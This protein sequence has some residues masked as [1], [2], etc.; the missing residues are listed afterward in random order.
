M[1]VGG[2]STHEAGALDSGGTRAPC[3]E[4]DAGGLGG[5]RIGISVS[6]PSSHAGDTE[7]PHV[8]AL[9]WDR[10]QRGVVPR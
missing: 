8:W 3:P 7:R 4:T 1:L 9:H 6:S 10:G 5:P 2:D